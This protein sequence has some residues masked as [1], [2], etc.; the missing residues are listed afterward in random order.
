MSTQLVVQ[1]YQFFFRIILRKFYFSEI[2]K[3]NSSGQLRSIP[4]GDKRS[5]LY[6]KFNDC[7]WIKNQHIWRNEVMFC[8]NLGFIICWALIHLILSNFSFLSIG[9]SFSRI[10]VL[11]LCNC[12]SKIILHVLLNFISNHSLSLICLGLHEVCKNFKQSRHASVPKKENESSGND[13]WLPE[14]WSCTKSRVLIPSI[15]WSPNLDETLG[16]IVFL[17]ICQ[18]L[19]HIQSFF[20]LTCNQ[21]F[22][23][24]RLRWSPCSIHKTSVKKQDG[25]N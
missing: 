8:L 21:K 16:N 10:F 1:T 4:Q 24:N 2:R 18:I 11:L 9:N 14:K 6:R 7:I 22:S 25:G 15:L 3:K 19:I 5:R 13:A 12:F 17:Q 20:N 23:C